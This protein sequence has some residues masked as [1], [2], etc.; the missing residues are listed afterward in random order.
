MFPIDRPLVRDTHLYL[1]GRRPL[2]LDSKAWFA[3][4]SQATYFRFQS[5][6]ATYR[7]TLRQEKRRHSF[8]WY[9]YLKND[10]KLHNAYVG[11][12]SQVTQ[13]RLELV[14]SQLVRKVRRHTQ[15]P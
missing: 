3:W 10:R 5:A 8:Y 4:L 15:P 9:A 11:P 12:T 13:E 2:P 7:L 1:P 6:T 14:L